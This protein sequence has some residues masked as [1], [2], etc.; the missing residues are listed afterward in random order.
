MNSLSRADIVVFHL[1]RR[2]NG[3]IPLQRFLDSYRANPAGCDHA[4][5][6]ILKGFGRDLSQPFEGLVAGASSQTIAVPDRGLDI[7]AY[8]LAARAIQCRYACFLNSFSEIRSAN[9][10]SYLHSGI[11]D[12]RVGMVGASGTWQSLRA[13]LGWLKA[14]SSPRLVDRALWLLRWLRYCFQIR[15]YF[16]DFPNPHLRTNAFL[17]ERQRFLQMYRPLRTKLDHYRFESGLTGLSR[18]IIDS[19]LELRVVGRNGQRYPPAQWPDS[20]TFWSGDQENLLIADNQSMLYQRATAS[21][22]AKLRQ[23]AWGASD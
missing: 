10:L 20:R 21:E 4:L 8:F 17:I 6:I 13:N 15:D 18:A 11:Q 14:E 9:W 12:E 16:A 23:Y 1:V 5:V 3:I 22:R 19:G 7:G 2:K